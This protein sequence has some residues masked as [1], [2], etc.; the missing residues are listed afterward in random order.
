MKKFKVTVRRVFET[1]IFVTADNLEEVHKALEDYKHK[2]YDDLTEIL[3]NAEMEVM[4][5]IEQSLEVE[6][7]ENEFNDYTIL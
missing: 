3:Y 7:T 6:E 5:V 1:E 2:D 4:N